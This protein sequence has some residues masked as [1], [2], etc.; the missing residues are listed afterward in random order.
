[1]A[2]IYLGGP[3]VPVRE[4]VD[5]VFA[6]MRDRGARNERGFV[7]LTHHSHPEDE[8]PLFVQHDSIVA[9]GP[10][11]FDQPDAPTEDNQ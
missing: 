11:P 2:H 7:R 10:A 8:R 4:T 5:D 3:A 6:L 1:M 9:V